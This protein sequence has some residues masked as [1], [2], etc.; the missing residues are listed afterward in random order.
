MPVELPPDLGEYVRAAV[1]SGEF[2]SESALL[3]ETVRF[4][5]DRAERLAVLRGELRDAVDSLDRD[6]G[7]IVCGEAEHEAFFEEIE[8]RGRERLVAGSLKTASARLMTSALL[9]LVTFAG[10]A[11]AQPLALKLGPRGAA[12]GIAV[13]VQREPVDGDGVSTGSGT[14]GRGSRTPSSRCGRRGCGSPAAASPTTTSGGPTPSPSR[15]P[16]R[17]AGPASRSG[18]SARSAGPMT[19]PASPPSASGGASSRPGC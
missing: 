3:A 16:T 13:R 17:P 1:A 4:R 19:C 5:R 8:R 2:A 9:C 15:P 14:T 18:C 11:G 7:R 6:E 12:A 10:S